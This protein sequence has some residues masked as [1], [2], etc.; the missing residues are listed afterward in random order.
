MSLPQSLVSNYIF[1]YVYY[2]SFKTSPGELT[3]VLNAKMPETF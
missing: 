1:C 3:K 2:L